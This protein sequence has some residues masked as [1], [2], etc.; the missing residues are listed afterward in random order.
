MSVVKSKRGESEVEFIHT[1][2]ELEIFT[3][4]QC[5]NFP[6]RYT[7]YLSQPIVQL[8]VQVYDSVV[9]ANSIYPENRRDATLRR[10]HFVRANAALHS[11]IAQVEL[12]QELFGLA[13]EPTDKWMGYIEREIKLIQGVIRKDQERFSGYTE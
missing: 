5:V 1:A 8:A 4:R 6:K 7:F 10:D 9:K 2:R 12:A 11:M 3:M 13:P